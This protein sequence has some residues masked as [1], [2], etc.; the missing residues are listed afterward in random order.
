M[1]GKSTIALLYSNFKQIVNW[2]DAI[3]SNHLNYSY[4]CSFVISSYSPFLLSRSGLR[5]SS[6]RFQFGKNKL[7]KCSV[8]VNRKIISLSSL[9]IN[10]EGFHNTCNKNT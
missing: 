1:I 9:L 7:I 10:F 8:N 2:V 4:F 5:P 6:S 3:E